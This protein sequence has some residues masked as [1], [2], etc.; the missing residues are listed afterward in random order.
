MKTFSPKWLIGAVSALLVFTVI[1]CNKSD[2]ST[3]GGLK[4]N[5]NN[6]TV[7][8][9]DGPGYFDS[10]FVNI[11][12]IAVKIDTTQKWWGIN[13]NNDNGDNEG[14]HHHEWKNW[15]SNWGNE[16]ESDHNSF[17]DTLNF[18]P[19]VYNLLSLANGAD[20]LL[21][22][23]NITKGKIIAFKI[24]LGST[25]NSLVKDGVTYPLNLMPG[26][27]SVYVRVFGENFQEVTT[28]H[29]KIWIDFDAGR[30][31]INVHDGQFYLRPFL[32]AYAVS[33]TGS[34]AGVVMPQDA[35]PVISVQNAGDTLYALPGRGGAFMVKGLPGGTYSVFV[36]A[37]NGYQDTTI[38]NVSVTTGKTT[39][40]G[41]I[42]LHK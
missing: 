29:Y 3:T 25:G 23:T 19:G 17:W 36:N 31:V 15:R 26:W 4:P 30:S 5:Q 38:N 18:T 20:T 21:S 13:N 11:Q 24:T 7:M 14:D 34:V 12:S 28:D 9:T 37:S 8:L 35:M 40:L 1:S 22:S 6:L 42:N 27:N 39:K 32:R 33:N 2:L 41:I 16:D 10:V